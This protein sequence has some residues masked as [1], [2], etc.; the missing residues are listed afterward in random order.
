MLAKPNSN[1][2]RFDLFRIHGI[3]LVRS[4]QFGQP[5]AF[6]FDLPLLYFFFK[7]NCVCSHLIQFGRGGLRPLARSHHPIATAHAA[8]P[9]SAPTAGVLLEISGRAVGELQRRVAWL[10]AAGRAGLAFTI[11]SRLFVFRRGSSAGK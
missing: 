2:N 10:L 8:A 4:T 6:L 11:F 5:L 3:Y 9:F 7:Q 1:N